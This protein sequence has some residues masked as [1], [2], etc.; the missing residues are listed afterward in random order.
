[1][2][3]AFPLLRDDGL[4]PKERYTERSFLDAELERLWPRLWQ[5]AC[6][7]EEIAEVGAYVEYTIGDDS[8]LLVRS[9][10]DAVS[11]FH[12]VCLHRGTR[13]ATGAGTFRGGSF[14]CPFHGWCYGL[15]GSLR[16]VP[17]RHEFGRLPA[18]GD[19]L[20]L[21]SFRFAVERLK[22]IRIADVAVTR[23]AGRR[24]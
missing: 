6:R 2:T 11:A 13:L 10:P 17:D 23:I 9:A 1:M 4:V 18:R 24:E 15:D 20:V 19:S 7:E 3:A 5:I 14:A 22:G 16:A 21:G 8:I 12:N